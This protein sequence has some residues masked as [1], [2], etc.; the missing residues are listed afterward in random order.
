MSNLNV[1]MLL[2]GQKPE[3]QLGYHTAFLEETKKGRLV[4][5]RSFPYGAARS[6]DEWSH[7]WSDVIRHMRNSGSNVLYLQYFHSPNIP[8]PRPFIEVVKSLRQEPIVVTSCGD[9]FGF[10]GARPPSSLIRAASQSDVFFTTAM[11]RLS[12]IF[13]HAGARRI[14]LMPNSACD[15]RFAGTAAPPT[16]RPFDVIFI[17]SNRHSRNP[18]SIYCRSGRRREQYVTQLQRRYGGKLGLFGHGWK[19]YRSW[20]GPVSFDDQAIM[21]QSARVIFGG[22]PG[23]GEYFYT[24]NRPFIQMLSRVPLIDYRVSGVD[25]LLCDGVDWLLFNELTDGI[26]LI[27]SILED[28]HQGDAIGTAGASTVCAK[29]LNSH[30]VSLIIDILSEVLDARRSR[31]EAVC[32]PLDFFREGVRGDAQ[33]EGLRRW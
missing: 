32:P 6:I 29:H 23:T 14:T 3:D 21:C 18:L 12:R 19:G 1:T 25:S 33:R 7:L 10:L 4:G 27:D 16:D 11:G 24:S 30:R 9:A 8:D 20:Q 22:F 28:P 13:E 15:I 5:Y 2:Q 17:G 26:R 31:R